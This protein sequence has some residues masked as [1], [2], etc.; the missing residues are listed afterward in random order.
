[1]ELLESHAI[2]AVLDSEVGFVGSMRSAGATRVFVPSTM[3]D[4]AKAVLE[5]RSVHGV[6]ALPS[7][8]DLQ[9]ENRIGSSLPGGDEEETGPIDFEP[10]APGALAP[11]LSVA[12]GAVAFGLIAQ[13]VCEFFLGSREAIAY[14]GAR[15]PVTE[16]VWQPVTAGFMHGSATHMG[17]NA[18]F[19]VFM[20]VVLFGTHQMGATAFVWLFASVVGIMC[21][22][23]LT[24][25]VIVIG[26]SAGNYGLVGL[27]TAG[28]WERARASLL[29]RRE[30]I[31]TLGVLLLLVPGALTPISS[32][33]S[34]VAVVAHVAGYVAGLLLGW[35]FRRR[36]HLAGFERIGRRSRWAGAAAVAIGLSAWAVAVA[37]LLA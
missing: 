35:F 22:A 26:A 24:P 17:G 14:L 25:G 12:L 29:T 32:T 10:P 20:A 1:M 11:R 34:R 13:R 31:R 5:E 27:W 36:L 33:G 15:F 16:A 2:L 30:I 23:A 37:A 18:I 21:E 9:R 3:L 19:G 6:W 4:S 28:R 7:Q 8:A